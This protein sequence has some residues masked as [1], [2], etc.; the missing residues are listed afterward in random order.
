MSLSEW[1]LSHCDLPN[2][3]IGKFYDDRNCDMTVPT[4]TS[5]IYQCDIY[6]H[7][8]WAV[9]FRSASKTAVTY[10][11]DI[12]NIVM[13]TI[14][15]LSNHFVKLTI[16]VSI[17]KC[18]TVTSVSGQCCHNVTN[19]PFHHTITL[20]IVMSSDSIENDIRHVVFCKHFKL[21]IC[22]FCVILSLSIMTAV[23]LYSVTVKFVLSP[24]SF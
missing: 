6:H 5:D 4:L 15:T 20:K 24:N 2:T 11:D 23:T 21:V 14:D 9:I 7:M 1:Q 13:T 19:V 12:Y 17:V 8:F 22:Q 16:F 3:N 10:Y 18:H